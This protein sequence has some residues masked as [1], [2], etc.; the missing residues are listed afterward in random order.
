MST[1]LLLQLI[2]PTVCYR[3]IVLCFTIVLT[4]QVSNAAWP[5]SVSGNMKPGQKS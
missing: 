1:S 4:S 3:F 2:Y 5:V